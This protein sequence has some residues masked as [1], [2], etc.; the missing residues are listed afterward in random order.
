MLVARDGFQ[1]ALVR[2]L[3]VSRFSHD[4]AICATSFGSTKSNALR[5]SAVVICNNESGRLV[6]RASYCIY[7]REQPARWVGMLLLKV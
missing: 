7:E 2:T 6:L 4:G 1:N 3:R 5:P